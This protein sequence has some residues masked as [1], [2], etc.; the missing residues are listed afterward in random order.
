MR[1]AGLVAQPD[2]LIDEAL[3]AQVLGQCRRQ[4]E[5]RIGHQ[6]IVVEGRIEAVEAVR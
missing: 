6:A 4:E 1:P 2:V 3:Q 5:P